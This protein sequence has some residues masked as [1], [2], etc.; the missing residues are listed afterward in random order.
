M[1]DAAMVNQMAELAESG[2]DIQALL[3]RDQAKAIRELARFGE[4]FTK[5]FR[6]RLR[7]LYACEGFEALGSILLVE[8]SAALSGQGAK[9]L[10]AVLRLRCGN[11]EQV[12]ASGPAR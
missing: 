8:A 6:K 3:E 12:L 7:R 11:R 4:R 10:E 1:G 9:P 5:A 2:R